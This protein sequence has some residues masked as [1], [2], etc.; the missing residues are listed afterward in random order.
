MTNLEVSEDKQVRLD[1]KMRDK[2]A[3]ENR[4]T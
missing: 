3:I 1:D 4:I 2:S